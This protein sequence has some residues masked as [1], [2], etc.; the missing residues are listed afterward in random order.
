MQRALALYR[1]D[2]RSEATREWNWGM[3]GLEDLQLLAA[4]ETASR[5]G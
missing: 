5:E 1:L 4:A 3:R 2:W